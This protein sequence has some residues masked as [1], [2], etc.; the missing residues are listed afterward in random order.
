MTSLSSGARQQRDRRA[1][2]D[3]R[4][5]HARRSGPDKGATRGEAAAGRRARQRG[6]HPGLMA[7]SC[8]VRRRGAAYKPSARGCRDAAAG[9]TDRFDRR[10]LDD[11]AGIHHR[12]AVADFGDHAEIVRDQQIAVSHLSLAAVRAARGSAPG[13]SHRARW[14]AHRRSAARVAGQRHRDHDALAHAAG[15]LVRIVIARCS[16]I[17]MP[18]C[19]SISTAPCAP[20]LLFICDGERAP[21]RSDRRS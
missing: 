17:G 18:T 12:H 2:V 14:S 19:R 11:F 8:S 13:S 4:R 1:K 3:D 15:K 20:P 7:A 10:P 16:G 21:R 5:R 6:H 9:R